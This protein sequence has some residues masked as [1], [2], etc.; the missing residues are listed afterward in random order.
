MQERQ[1][2]YP[3]PPLVIFLNN[4]DGLKINYTGQAS[5]KTARFVAKYGNGPL[6]DQFKDKSIGKGYLERW[7]T[8]FYAA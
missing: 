4:N 2:I 6:T 1:K 5:E 3:D 7:E 8:T